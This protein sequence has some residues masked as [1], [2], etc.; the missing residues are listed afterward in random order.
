MKISADI[1]HNEFSSL[2]IKGKRTRTADPGSSGISARRVLRWTLRIL[3]RILLRGKLTNETRHSRDPPNKRYFRARLDFSGFLKKQQA[4]DAARIAE[5]AFPRHRNGNPRLE[6]YLQAGEGEK[7]EEGDAL[8][9][10]STKSFCTQPASE[11]GER[12]RDR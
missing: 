2:W 9:K 3:L 10:K 12:E 1:F 6:I 4:G 5:V 7:D 11:M 8:L